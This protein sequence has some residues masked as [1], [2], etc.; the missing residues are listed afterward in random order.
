MPMQLNHRGTTS[1]R[2]WFCFVLGALGVLGGSIIPSS[3]QA[4]FDW[5]KESIPEKWIRPLV[6]EEEKDAKYPAYFG[7]LDKARAQMLG[8]LYRRSLVTLT[9]AKDVDPLEAA[10]VRASSLAALGRN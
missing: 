8:G 10:I 1:P 6:P 9:T 3:A 2:S 7:D 4:A 5:K